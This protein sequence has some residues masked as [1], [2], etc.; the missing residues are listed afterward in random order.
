VTEFQDINDTLQ[1]EGVEGVRARHDRAR[2]YQPSGKGSTAEQSKPNTHY[3]D[4]KQKL[5]SGISVLV[6]AKASSLKMTIIQWLWPDRFAIG[7][8]GII[9]GLPDEGKGQT[10]AFIAAQVTNGGQWPMNR[11]F[12][13]R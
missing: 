4:H 5:R 13:A 10:L 2:K 12:A 11:T 6:S 9:A 7:K 8:L 1:T 3:K